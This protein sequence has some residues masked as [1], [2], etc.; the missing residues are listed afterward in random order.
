M[1]VR[2]LGVL[3]AL[4][5]TVVC[6]L[7]WQGRRTAPPEGPGADAPLLRSFLEETVRGIDLACAGSRVTLG[8]EA[9]GAWRITEPLIAEADPRRVHDVVAALQGVKIRKAIAETA[10]DLPAFGLDPAACTV[11]VDLGTATPAIS[12]RVGRSSPVGNGRYASADDDRVVLT[13]GSVYGVVSQGAEA[14]REKRLFP[15]DPET[16]TRID[17][18]R[19]DGRLVVA[20]A[21]GTWRVE[22]PRSDL[23]S[24]A[25]CT[26]LA[27]AIASIE[28]TDTGAAPMRIG[29]KPDRRIALAITSSRRSSPFVAFVAAAGIDGKRLG[30]RDGGP[31]AGLVEEAAAR[32]LE[33]PVDAFRDPRVT[34]FSAP[35]AR[36]L[37]IMRGASV[38]RVLRAGEGSPWEGSEGA[39]PMAVDGSRVDALLDRLRGLM[40]A[41]FEGGEP[42]TR[43]TG[44][45]AVSGEKGDLA[46]LTWGPLA[47]ST[48]GGDESVWMTTAARPGTVFR[49]E[50]VSFGPIPANAADLAPAEPSKTETAGGS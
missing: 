39:T 4:L 11:R 10:A 18:T 41:G 25:A 48:H 5:A 13:D 14:L 12:L 47:P 46:R 30:W 29:A 35:D 26:S 7:V 3:F 43:P 21:G 6:L 28:L 42:P 15:V 33:Q 36:R 32:E 44:T 20:S 8:R 24:A 22:A 49:V 37:S 9:S 45:I 19:P 31:F 1:S 16:I 50:A 23:A 17:L 2:G 40:S 38:L 27:R 34:S